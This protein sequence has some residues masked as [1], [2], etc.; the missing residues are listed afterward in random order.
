M[1]CTYRVSDDENWGLEW[2]RVEWGNL[3]NGSDGPS[4]RNVTGRKLLSEYIFTKKRT[5][6]RVPEAPDGSD[7]DS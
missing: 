3:F 6:C 2:L 1:G 4:V 7:F 5:L